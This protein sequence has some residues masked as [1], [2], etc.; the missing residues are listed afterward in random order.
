[1]ANIVFSLNLATNN[2][3]NNNGRILRMDNC[4]VNNKTYRKQNCWGLGAHSPNP[5]EGPMTE[6]RKVNYGYSANEKIA[7][8]D[9]QQIEQRVSLRLR[10][11]HD[12]IESKI[13]KRL[14]Q[15]NNQGKEV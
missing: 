1:M 11:I 7:H 15:I 12:E 3:H 9:A 14:E 4:T 8:F 2:Y 13:S 10:Q 5:E 6:H